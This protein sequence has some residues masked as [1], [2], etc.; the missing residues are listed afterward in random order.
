MK[1]VIEPE[2][3]RLASEVWDFRQRN[4]LTQKALAQAS[5][6]SLRQIAYMESASGGGANRSIG[7]LTRKRWL[8]FKEK[9]KK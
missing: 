6:I 5:G 2:D 7:F 9:W 4:F 8:E 3:H 1:L